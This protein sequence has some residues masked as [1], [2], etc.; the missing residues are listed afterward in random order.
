MIKKLMILLCVV[1]LSA[2]ATHTPVKKGAVIENFYVDADYKKCTNGRYKHLILSNNVKYD[3]QYIDE[4]IAACLPLLKSS[5]D[6]V[7]AGNNGAPQLK[8]L[9]II[10]TDK[11]LRTSEVL[12]RYFDYVRTKKAEI[13]SNEYRVYMEAYY[14]YAM[15]F[16][17]LLG[18]IDI[19]MSPDETYDVVDLGAISPQKYA[20]SLIKA[21]RDQQKI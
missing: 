18:L 20:Q 13:S 14:L 2:C 4:I 8:N 1:V 21:V 16:N 12:P 7:D 17:V 11:V 5:L 9:A 19:S 15:S 6:F 10:M 3:T